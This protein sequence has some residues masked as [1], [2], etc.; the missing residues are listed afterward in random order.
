MYLQYKNFF[1]EE[2]EEIISCDLKTLKIFLL[3]KIAK[4]F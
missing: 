3:K 2:I 4:E 1:P